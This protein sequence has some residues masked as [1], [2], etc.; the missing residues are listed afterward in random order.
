[1]II[2]VPKAPPSGVV[3][4]AKSSTSVRVNWQ[5]LVDELILTGTRT[6]YEVRYALKDGSPKHWTSVIVAKNVNLHLITL[7]EE[8]TIYEIKVAAMTTKGSGVF[9]SPSTV[10]TKEDSKLSFRTFF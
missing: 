1:M 10:R 6:G 3:V 9:S 7:L 8:Y 5:H 4:L 2:L